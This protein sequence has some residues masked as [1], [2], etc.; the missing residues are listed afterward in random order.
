VVA[1]V[2][3]GPA[4][5]EVE[6]PGGI[7]VVCQ[8]SCEYTLRKQTLHYLESEGAASGSQFAPDYPRADSYVDGWG[9]RHGYLF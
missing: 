6:L 4:G 2:R 1:P 7:W 3:R 8:L 5:D 9:Y